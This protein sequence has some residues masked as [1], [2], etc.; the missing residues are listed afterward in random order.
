MVELWREMDAHGVGEAD[1]LV[2]VE[3]AMRAKNA[4]REPGP[5]SNLRFFLPSIRRFAAAS[6]AEVAPLPIPS[7]GGAAAG[8]ARSQRRQDAEERERRIVDAAVHGTAKGFG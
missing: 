1:V 2:L 3:E 4:G 6:R 5:P 8:G 7:P